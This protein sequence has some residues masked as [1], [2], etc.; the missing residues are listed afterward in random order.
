MRSND[1][2]SFLLYELHNYDEDDI[3]YIERVIIDNFD[4]GLIKDSAD[5]AE[6]MHDI[7]SECNTISDA[8]IDEYFIASLT[9][10]ILG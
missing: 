5:V 7:Y 10:T 3:L 1:I 4:K 2:Y 8:I 6:L 9:D